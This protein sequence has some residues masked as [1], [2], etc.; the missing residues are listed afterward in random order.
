MGVVYEVEQ[1]LLGRRVALKILPF[2]AAL[3]PGHLQRFQAEAQAAQLHHTHI[4]PVHAVGC[5]Q[6]V[7]YYAMQLIDG[8]SLAD[9]IAQM[10][11]Q[12]GMEALP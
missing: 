8:Q 6:G 3:D 5:E 4:V 11:R 1:V 12:A 7:H 10:R 2:A 9:A